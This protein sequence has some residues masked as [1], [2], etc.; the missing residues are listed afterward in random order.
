M[1]PGSWGWV[2]RAYASMDLLNRPGV[3]E[4]IDTPVVLFGT[5]A[6]RLV[7]YRAIVRAAARLPHAELLTFGRESAH[8]ILRESDPVRDKALA[9]IDGFLDRAAPPT[10]R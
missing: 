8:E 6:D 7:S 1:G 2:E 10:A 9:A 4:A 3:L 5:T